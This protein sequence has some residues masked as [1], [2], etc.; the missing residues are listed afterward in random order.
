MKKG[1]ENGF[2]AMSQHVV[3]THFCMHPSAMHL[4]GS[5]R[6]WPCGLLVATKVS[7]FATYLKTLKWGDNCKMPRNRALRI[8]SLTS[9]ILRGLCWMVRYWS[10]CLRRI[11]VHN[12]LTIKGLIFVLFRFYVSGKPGINYQSWPC[13][14]QHSSQG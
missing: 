8:L 4:V 3:P 2:L 13:E 14:L 5:G 12:V 10:I 11:P 7:P 9:L 1:P 6:F